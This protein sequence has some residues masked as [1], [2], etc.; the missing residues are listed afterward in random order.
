MIRLELLPVRFA[1]H[2]TKLLDILSGSAVQ[3]LIKEAG[4]VLHP[5]HIFAALEKL[6][7]S[8]RK[9]LKMPVPDDKAPTYANAP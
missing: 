5:E 4:V 1:A 2:L 9:K 8:A 6:R 7:V 3:A